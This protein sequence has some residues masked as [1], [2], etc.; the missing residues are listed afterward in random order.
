MI[1]KNQLLKKLAIEEIPFT[2]HIHRPLFTVADSEKNRG[3]IQGSHTKN[4]FLKNKKNEFFLITCNENASVELKKLGKSLN[5]GNLSFAKE[6][7]L[8]EYLGVLPGSVTPF[9]LLNDEQH[10]VIF[11]IDSRLFNEN[12][13][14]FH[15]LINTSTITLKTN[16]FINFMVENK[17]KV[18]ILDLESYSLI[19][20]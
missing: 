18:N 10:K 19:G 16:D 5:L 9:G 6:K 4:L 17:K 3:S 13:I 11:Y 1:T 12:K 15:P 14:N 20:W 8:K 7:K 2:E